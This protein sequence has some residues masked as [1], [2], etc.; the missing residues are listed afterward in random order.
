ME[1]IF[2]T[3]REGK[4]RKKMASI[5]IDRNFSPNLRS[6]EYTEWN[7]Q[8][9]D[10]SKWIQNTQQTD[11]L[12]LDSIQQ[13]DNLHLLNTVEVVAETKEECHYGDSYLPAKS[14]CFTMISASL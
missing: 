3:K 4:D 8:W 13:V 10:V 14:G 9:K 5:L 12:Y 6:Y 7:P 2:Q 1:A 11:S